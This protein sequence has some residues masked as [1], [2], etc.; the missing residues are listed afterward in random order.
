MLNVCK[1]ALTLYFILLCILLSFSQESEYLH[2]LEPFL[3]ELENST[4]KVEML[5]TISWDLKYTHPTVALSYAEECLVI[6]EEIGYQRGRIKCLNRQANVYEITGNFSTAIRFYHDARIISEQIEDIYSVGRSHNAISTNFRLMEQYDSALIHSNQAIKAFG[7][8][9]TQAGQNAL[10][11]AYEA[12]GIMYLEA[13]NLSPALDAFYLSIGVR[14]KIKDQVGLAKCHNSIGIY[15]ETI[16]LYSLA[17]ESFRK[18]LSIH[19]KIAYEDSAMGRREII[20]SLTNISNAHFLLGN[21]TQA[22]DSIQLANTLFSQGLKDPVLHAKIYHLRGKVAQAV[23]QSDL[24]EEYYEKGLAIRKDLGIP[25]FL[26]ESYK[27][28][29]QLHLQQDRTQQAKQDLQTGLEF[30]AENNDQILESELYN[31]LAFVYTAM[32]STQQ[33]ADY[34]TKASTTQKN[35]VQY[36]RNAMTYQKQIEESRHQLEI[37]QKD[38]DQIR[39]QVIGLYIGIGLLILIAMVVFLWIKS[40]QKAV[41]ATKNE[42][43]AIRS[44]KIAIKESQLSKEKLFTIE[45]TRQLEQAKAVIDGQEAERNRISKDLHDVLGGILSLAQ[46][47]LKE[48]SDD[49]STLASKQQANFQKANGLIEKA[50]TSVRDISHDLGDNMLVT[51]GL[52][53]TL[54]A[55]INEVEENSHLETNYG[56]VGL[57]MTDR[58]EHLLEN[59]IYKIVRELT[60]N[61]LRHAEAKS[62]HVNIRKAEEALTVMVQDDGKGFDLKNMKPTGMG[63]R[64]IR[65]RLDEIDGTLDIDAS[66]DSETQTTF[67][68]TIPL[69]SP[70][71]KEIA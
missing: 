60:T 15:Y 33:V 29:G 1:L 40:R 4:Q 53:P 16:G 44:E 57:H 19:Q 7:Q 68:L 23:G 31:L 41:I 52:I 5:D 71:I 43:L 46:T 63:M 21:W 12:Q 49:V 18:S 30:V 34:F 36:Q 69:R 67:T 22:Q 42:Q 2:R 26:A 51:L 8:L 25:T 39:Q 54:E 45:Q 58:F 66:L 9:T 37:A 50:I 6:A 65:S 11:T 48:L 62:L 70:S 64:N 17:L 38:R 35:I 47:T 59:H 3:P 14:E 20:V 56:Y 55:Y 24:A 32:D 61:V 10:G 28:I 13:G 27:D